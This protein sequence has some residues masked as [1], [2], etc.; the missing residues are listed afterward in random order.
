[1]DAWLGIVTWAAEEK[2]EDSVRAK[3]T[4]LS[5]CSDAALL[6]FF[7]KMSKRRGKMNRNGQKNTRK[8]RKEQLANWPIIHNN[9]LHNRKI[10]KNI[11]D[12]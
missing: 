2:T 4:A 10:D 7:D 6:L 3:E 12:V 1:M 5:D 9:Q 11:S 8:R